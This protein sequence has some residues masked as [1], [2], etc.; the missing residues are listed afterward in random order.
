MATT[1]RPSTRGPRGGSGG[2]YGYEEEATVSGA[3]PH[4]VGLKSLAP[5]RNRDR[6]GEVVDSSSSEDDDEARRRHRRHNRNEEDYG[7]KSRGNNR[8]NYRSNNNDENVVPNYDVESIY[9]KNFFFQQR[10]GNL[11]IRS[12]SQLDLDRVV[13]DVDID[14]IQSHL[15]NITFCHLRE[16]DMR[17]LTDPL[18]VKVNFAYTDLIDTL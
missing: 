9:G 5:T 3:Q 7:A 2:G 15:E 13:R 1:S 8:N 12:L 4:S 6:R 10:R 14:T 11:D 16:E 18:V 17:L